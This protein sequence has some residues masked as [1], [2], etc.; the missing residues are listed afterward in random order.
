MRGGIDV[1]TYPIGVHSTTIT[2]FVFSSVEMTP[3]L[4]C[5]ILAIL[6]LLLLVGIR[7][8]FES[9]DTVRPEIMKDYQAFAA[10][11]RP[12]L[13]NWEKAI[14]TSYELQKPAQVSTQAL[15]AAPRAELNAYIAKVSQEK[16]VALPSL[17]DALP[18]TIAQPTL[19][20]LLTLVPT[21]STPYLNALTWMNTQL[22]TAQQGLSSMI[23]PVEGFI[24]ARMKGLP[25]HEGFEIEGFEA[26]CDQ[27]A[28]CMDAR[29]QAKQAS[30]EQELVRRLAT[31][32]NPALQTAM[33]EN[34]R[35][36]GKAEQIQKQAQSGALLS[37][38]SLPKET[39]APL[40]APEGGSRLSELQKNDPAQYKSLQQQ[41]GS[42]FALK[43]LM[44]QIN[45]TL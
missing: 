39:S 25:Q 43:G 1:S 18:E 17:T 2:L 36:V 4:G 33:K 11:Y 41:G 38:F 31:F 34:K 42:M 8:G 7:E 12:F 20:L 26:T 45:R 19:S 23:K 24:W 5:I 22:S 10:F 14:V 30:Q 27:I 32:Q 29:D 44:E 37:Q 21:D 40:I 13:V 16:G 15:S 6:V 35:L 9:P 3:L 28:K